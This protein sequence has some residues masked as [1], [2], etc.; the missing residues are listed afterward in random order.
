MRDVWVDRLTNI[1]L[2]VNWLLPAVS[3]LV[4]YVDKKFLF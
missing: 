1:F 4:S 3:L 2:G